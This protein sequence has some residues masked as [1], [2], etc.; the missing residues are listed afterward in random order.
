MYMPDGSPYKWIAY[1][2]RFF[3]SLPNSHAVIYCYS[4]RIYYLHLRGAG[5]MN[6]AFG[7]FSAHVRKTQ[8]QALCH[9]GGYKHMQDTQGTRS[10]LLGP[11]F[12]MLSSKKTTTKTKGAEPAVVLWVV[13]PQRKFPKLQKGDSFHIHL[14]TSATHLNNWRACF[15]GVPDRGGVYLCRTMENKFTSGTWKREVTFSRCACVRGTCD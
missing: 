9:N 12:V 2:P 13:F 8:L 1:K 5:I 4:L 10:A 7:P 14:N 15:I 11:S 3:K 6:A